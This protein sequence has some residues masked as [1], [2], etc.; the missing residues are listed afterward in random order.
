MLP[1]FTTIFGFFA[2]FLPEVLKYFNTKQANEHELAI[3]S[4]QREAAKDQHLYK[5]SE[6]EATADIQEAA[7]IRQ[8]QVSFGVQLLDAAKDKQM[9]KWA[10]AP[11]FYMFTILDFVAGMTRPGITWACFGLYAAAKLAMLGV[12]LD[13]ATDSITVKQA[14]IN[15]WGEYDQ[16][17]LQLVLSYWFGQ[18]AAKAAFGG[19]ASNNSAGK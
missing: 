15:S 4:L 10:L 18:R 5:M 2:P 9:G 14:I 8:P 7:S 1:V 3:L 11:A 12:G 19:N 17:M 16:A 13:L 6:I